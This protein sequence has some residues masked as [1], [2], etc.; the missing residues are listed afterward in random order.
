L[1]KSAELK[2]LSSAFVATFVGSGIFFDKGF[3]KVCDK[4]VKPAL[5]QQ[6]LAKIL[7][8]VIWKLL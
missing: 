7:E 6:A 3:D 4:D 2:T 8:L 1:Q 5:S